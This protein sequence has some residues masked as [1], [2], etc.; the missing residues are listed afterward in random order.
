MLS[1]AS[2]AAA[3]RQE[4]P[5]P[6]A[7]PVLETTPQAQPAATGQAAVLAILSPAADAVLQGV[8]PILIHTDV[9]GFES[10]EVAFTYAGDA[11]GTWFALYESNQPLAGAVALEWD[12]GAITDGD[13]TLRLMIALSDGNT[14]S[15]QTT[16]LRVRNYSAVETVTPIAAVPTAAP[17][18]TAVPATSQPPAPATATVGTQVATETLAATATF[19]PPA[20]ETGA[21]QPANPAELAPE[22]VSWSAARGGIAALGVFALAGIYWS[23]RRL[24][25][26]NI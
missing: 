5:T 2:L 22:Q 9:A 8:V 21:T 13:Y 20:V 4:A 15:V 10:A 16:G 23:L 17:D 12:T 24:G 19:T 3:G 7:P 1:L 18:L 14:Q 25:K 6:T 11:T 26:R